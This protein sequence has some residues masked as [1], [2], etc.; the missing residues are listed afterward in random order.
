M[1]Y[2]RLWE[3]LL[4]H[5]DSREA[6]AIT[7][8]LAE[9]LLGL[10]L[11]D[12][13]CGALDTL[14]PDDQ[15]R[16]DTAMA[17]LTRGEPLQYVLGQTEFAGRTFRVEPGVLIPRPETE[18]LC[19][20]ITDD[21]RQQGASPISIL[22]IGSGSGCIAC[23]LAL[24][25]N[26]TTTSERSEG[27]FSYPITA[28][29]TAWDLY[30]TPLRLT[31]DNSRCLGAGLTTERR[32]ALHL[33]DDGRRWDIIVS[34]PPYV[35]VAEKDE[36]HRNVLD[37]EPHEALF[38]PDDDPLRFYR[39]IAAYAAIALRPAGRLYFEINPLTAADLTAMLQQMGY[40]A[41]ELLADERGLQ[42]FVRAQ[43]IGDSQSDISIDP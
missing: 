30:D 43:R 37:Y 34:N 26:G 14:S 32:D 38:V 22:D 18:Q 35:M 15:V 24:N 23:T 28:S 25:L 19:R 16:I 3:Q 27:A 4:P 39:A 1:T 2:R 7:R 21:A 40:T 20:T 11:T 36:M 12:I 13:L 6:Q 29:V 42:R 17:R 5:Y 9:E 8:R 31:A 41:V 33:A 10:S